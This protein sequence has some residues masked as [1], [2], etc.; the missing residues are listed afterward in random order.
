I[1]I[2]YILTE[3]GGFW[4]LYSAFISYSTGALLSYVLNKTLNFKNRSPYYL[5]QGIVF[6]VI[7]GC[8]LLLNLGI[9]Y[10]GVEWA[11]ISYIYAKI[12]ATGAAFMLN[13]AGQT[14]ITF[15]RWR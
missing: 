14:I 12:L 6:L 15:R 4:F 9:I 7:S 11:G 2:L 8:S 13:Y 1:G 5:T 3:W 10:A